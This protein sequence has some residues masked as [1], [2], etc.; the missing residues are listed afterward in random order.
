MMYLRT[1]P[2]EASQVSFKVLWVTSVTL[3]LPAGGGGTD[4]ATKLHRNVAGG[5]KKR[6]RRKEKGRLAES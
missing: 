3:S 6:G 2:G 1:F 4:G 5:A